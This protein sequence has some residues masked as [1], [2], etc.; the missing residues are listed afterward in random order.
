MCVQ[1]HTHT[2]HRVFKS[3]VMPLMPSLI[4]ENMHGINTAQAHF[5]DQVA[6]H[7]LLGHRSEVFPDPS[8]W[9]GRGGGTLPDQWK[10][11]SISTV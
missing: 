7:L 11:I 2:A 10:V 4:L 9:A 6:G 5:K 3:L 1:T 8:G